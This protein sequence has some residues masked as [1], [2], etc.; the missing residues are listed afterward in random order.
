MSAK[1]YMRLNQDGSVSFSVDN[2][3]GN[4][5]LKAVKIRDIAHMR[6]LSK[7]ERSALDNK[8]ND[9]QLVHASGEIDFIS[10]AELVSRYRFL[11]GQKITMAYL[12]N[13]KR[14]TVVSDCNKEYGIILLP[15]HMHGIFKGKQIPPNSYIIAPMDTNNNIDYDNINIISKKLFRKLF[16]IPPQNI[17]KRNIGRYVNT[18]IRERARSMRG[19]NINMGM[20]NPYNSQMIQ[21]K[22]TRNTDTNYNNMN[23]VQPNQRFLYKVLGKV[24]NENGKVIGFLVVDNKGVKR[25]L[26]ENK[27][28]ELCAKQLVSN[29]ILV[30]PERGIPFLRGNGISIESL[31]SYLQ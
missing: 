28:K 10:R 18:N 31:P 9:V 5:F 13:S 2:Y 27:V 11:N 21:N 12:K 3:R 19:M 23:N 20:Q 25:T 16:V 7:E 1:N 15:N 29:L 6:I 17:I 14:Y 26:S 8:I 22:P 4:S 24:I 30:R